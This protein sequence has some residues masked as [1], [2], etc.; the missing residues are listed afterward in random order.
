MIPPG[1]Q[2]YRTDV[3]NQF[4]LPF[5]TKAHYVTGHLHPYATALRLIDL[6]TG[7]ELFGIESEDFGDKIDVAKMTDFT[8]ELGVPIRKGGRYELVAD[9]NNTTDHEI[10]GMAILY[11][12]LA[13]RSDSQPA[14]TLAERN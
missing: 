11:L 14:A 12:Y 7:E 1:K 6:D 3:S 2:V 5:D 8:S 9:Y 10:D 4:E 13:E